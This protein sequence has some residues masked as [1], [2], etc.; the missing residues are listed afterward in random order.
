MSKALGAGFDL[1]RIFKMAPIL[2]SLDPADRVIALLAETWSLNKT[3]M[4]QSYSQLL[5]ARATKN[6][7]PMRAR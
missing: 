5:L 4:T 6:W 7:K 3:P 1:D 2:F